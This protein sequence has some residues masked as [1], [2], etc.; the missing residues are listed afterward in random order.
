M[1]DDGMAVKAGETMVRYDRINDFEVMA[2]KRICF[3][4]YRENRSSYCPFIDSIKID[5]YYINTR[6]PESIGGINFIKAK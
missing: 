4:P 5:G 3:L 6:Y 1:F 2:Q